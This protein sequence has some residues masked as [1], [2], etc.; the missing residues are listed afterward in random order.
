MLGN[1][2]GVLPAGLLYYRRGK[3]NKQTKK[4]KPQKH[5]KKG[6]ELRMVCVSSMYMHVCMRMWMKIGCTFTLS[7]P[8]LFNHFP[9]RGILMPV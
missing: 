7:L 5:P 2:F 8:A 4:K 6:Q 1:L 3:T 9:A